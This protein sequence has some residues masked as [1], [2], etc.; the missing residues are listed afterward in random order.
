LLSIASAAG[1][2]VETPTAL[3]QEAS[4][5]AATSQIVITGSRIATPELES[6]VPITI[7]NSQ[8]I[9]EEGSTNVSNLIRKLPSVGTSLL[10]TTNSNFLVSGSGI[11]S[12][13]LRN[14]GDQR[15]LVLVNGRRFTP[16][17]AGNSVVDFNM[18]P[19][20]F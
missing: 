2:A 16:G 5:E 13:N 9:Q 3:A 14:L 15:T 1:A 11:N 8:T 20:D 18:I 4:D 6:P 19:T 17:V 10:S 7:L 12:I